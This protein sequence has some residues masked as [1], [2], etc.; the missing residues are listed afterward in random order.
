MNERKQKNIDREVKMKELMIQMLKAFESR[1]AFERGFGFT[2]E[3]VKEMLF[4]RNS[5]LF[6]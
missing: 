4:D 6:K 2:P 5:K 3:E 1:E